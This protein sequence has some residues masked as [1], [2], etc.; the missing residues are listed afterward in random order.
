MNPKNHGLFVRSL[1][2]EG[3]LIIFY[4]MDHGDGGRGGDP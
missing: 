3:R 4:I 1:R 2:T